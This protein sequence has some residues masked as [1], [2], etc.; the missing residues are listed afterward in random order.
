MGFDLNPGHRNI[1]DIRPADPGRVK[2]KAVDD[3]I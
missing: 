1:F 2:G 3:R